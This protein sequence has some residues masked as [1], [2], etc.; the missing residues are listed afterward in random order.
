MRDAATHEQLALAYRKASQENP[1]RNLQPIKGEDPSVVNRPKDLHQP[2]GHPLFRR[3][4]HLGA[5]AGDSADS[6]KAWRTG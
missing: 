2:V 3:H 6:A 4:G 5:E 1:M